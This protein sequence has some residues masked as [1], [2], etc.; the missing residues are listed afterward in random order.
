M[1]IRTLTL[2]TLLYA[3]LF[4]TD[5]AA[6][7][8]SVFLSDT[9]FSPTVDYQGNGSVNLTIGNSGDAPLEWEIS[10]VAEEDPSFEG[11]PL[12]DTLRIFD[13]QFTDVTDLIPNR[14]DFTE[15]VTGTAIIDG[16]QD[17]FDIGNILTTNIASFIPYSDGI[18]ID[19]DS[20]G[21]NGRYFTRKYPGLFLLAA[22]ISDIIFFEIEGRFGNNA[23]STNAPVDFIHDKVY[24]RLKGSLFKHVINFLIITPDDPEIWH[25]HSNFG[26][27]PVVEKLN[28]INRI[29]YLLYA[30][31]NGSDI[32]D[33]QSQKIFEAAVK[34]LNPQ[35]E[36]LNVNRK[37][38]VVQAD[39]AVGVIISFDSINISSGTYEAILQI[40]TNDPVNTDF[41]IPVTLTVQ[42]P[43]PQIISVYPVQ[44]DFDRVAIGSHSS[45]PITIA[46]TGFFVNYC[47]S[48]SNFPQ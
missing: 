12:E 22:E 9:S 20:F 16:G 6:Q 29:Y 11:Q 28:N 30:S 41:S 38:G 17:K 4:S 37:S 27:R 39:N 14:F 34:I 3:T 31:E 24:S 15:G 47:G 2:S 48:I 32:D 35:S 26:Y 1:N 44:I 36:W 7:A 19:S 23:G 45:H 18:I 10:I 8:P 46:N 13:R 33:E 5:A 21:E 25:R 42:D 43:E 40:E